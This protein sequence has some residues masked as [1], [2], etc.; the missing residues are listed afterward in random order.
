[1]VWSHV[2]VGAAAGGV[3]PSVLPQ[4]W[5]GLGLRVYTSFRFGGKSLLAGTLRC[6][7]TLL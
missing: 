1:M 3:V 4:A 2:G 5:D 6:C 7:K